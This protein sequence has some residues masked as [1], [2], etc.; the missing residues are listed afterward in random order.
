M[1]NTRR[2]LLAAGGLFAALAA[3]GSRAAELAQPAAPAWNRAAFEAKTVADAL[4]A[5]GIEVARDGVELEVS[6]PEIAEDGA[7]V[8]VIVQ[9]R[10]PGTRE[11]HLL[12]DKNPFSLAASF[13][14]ADGTDP[15]VST[16]IKMAETSNVIA[17]ALAGG[18]AYLSRKQIK[19]TIGG[20]GG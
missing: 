4:K 10:A 8:P 18:Q 13:F 16:R 15:F 11:I 5:L 2:E 7:V 12:V 14:F 17:L 9:S 3:A 20:C 6:A 1:D 19:V